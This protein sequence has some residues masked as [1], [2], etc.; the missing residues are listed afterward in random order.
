MKRNIILIGSMGSG[1]SHIGRNLA[2]AL[3]WQF[4]DTDRL[5]EQQYGLPIAQVFESLGE[6]AFRQ[7]EA[8]VIN[9]VMFYHEAVISVGGN[10][11][12]SAKMIK[13]LKRY[14]FVIV[15]QASQQRIVNRVLRKIGKRPTMNYE[16]VSTFVYKMIG[17]WRSVY[18]QCDFVLDT[19]YGNSDDLVNSV[20]ET[21][22]RKKVEFK[23]RRVK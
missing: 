17:V 9:R 20:L 10:Y 3:Q 7:A 1:K 8:K 16:D 2:T 13:K 6:K 19:T 15:L 4:A 23:K 18:K 11:P 22:R 5:L 12:M 14:S 21:L